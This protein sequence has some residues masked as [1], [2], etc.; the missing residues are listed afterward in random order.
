MYPY[1]C[2][3]YALQHKIPKKDKLV[4][5]AYLGYLVR[6]DSRNIYQIW[7]PSRTRV[8]RTRDVTFDHNSYWSPDDLDI[9]NVLREDADQILDTLD[10]LQADADNIADD[11]VLDFIVVDHP[12]DHIE[13]SSDQEGVASRDTPICDNTPQ[14]LLIPEVSLEPT[15]GPM[16][17]MTPD[18]ESEPINVRFI[19]V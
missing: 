15:I 5:C 4:P 9:G 6:Y 16:P 8:I 3:A 17:T 2:W 7:I 18:P 1:G 11:K 13:E 19:S 10:L 14:Q 12:L